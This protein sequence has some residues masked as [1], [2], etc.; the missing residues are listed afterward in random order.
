[1]LIVLHRLI[2]SVLEDRAYS[3][4][5]SLLAGYLILV[6]A[7][8][9]CLMASQE[10]ESPSATPMSLPTMTIDT[11]SLSPEPTVPRSGT[12]VVEEDTRPEVRIPSNTVEP[13]IAAARLRFDSWSPDSQWL[14]YWFSDQD[15]AGSTSLVFANVNTGVVCQQ[16]EI[17]A[18]SLESGSVSW[19]AD[20]NVIVVSGLNQDA[21]IGAPCEALAS[22][23]NGSHPDEKGELSPNGR[24][25]AVTTFTSEGQL[26]HYTV[27]IT[28]TI[29]HQNIIT[30]SWKASVHAVKGG[31]SWLTNDLYLIGQTFQQGVLYLSLPNGQIGNVLTDLIGIETYDK[32]T[33]WWVFSQSQPSTGAYHLLLQW[34]GGSTAWSPLLLYH[35]ERDQVEELP[36][37]KA[38]HFSPSNT[39]ALSGF[40]PDGQWLIV[41]HLVEGGDPANDP[42]QD[43]WV[44]P[45][46][47]PG[48][49]FVQVVNQ[50]VLGGLSSHGHRLALFHD[51]SL[52]QI[53][54]FPEGEMLSQ[55]PIP[56]YDVDRLWWSPDDARLALWGI[57]VES[58]Q[59]VLFVI[60]P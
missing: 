23:E 10:P 57:D 11:S 28:D 27:T 51:N 15:E 37:Y 24:Y 4:R 17:V 52:I 12:T 30:F 47:P 50:A 1:M 20:G 59:E 31:P 48:G 22:T 32:E 21:W 2:F 45:V 43:Y 14:A 8:G 18:P 6:L 13:Y 39:S 58:G 56:G 49:S 41:G 5:L 26:L 40:S 60:E 34:W 25:H 44:R 9:G 29:A 46:D 36:F 16:A 55:W 35:G 7:L 53:V 33:T 38:R 42:G 54:S 3:Q 19:Q